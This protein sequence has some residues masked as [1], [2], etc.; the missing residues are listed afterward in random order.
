M[1]F[2]W[3]LPL[4]GICL[5]GLVEF[6][7]VESRRL[8]P[9]RTTSL[10]S[11]SFPG[12]RLS[13]SAL[14]LSWPFSVVELLFPWYSSFPGTRLSGSVSFFLDQSHVSVP[15]I[16]SSSSIIII[17]SS[18]SGQLSSLFPRIASPWSALLTLSPDR[19]SLVFA[20]LLGRSSVHLVLA[21]PLLFLVFASL[22][23]TRLSLVDFSFLR[24]R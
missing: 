19:L 4:L 13:G 6:K 1:L 22:L 9:R 7:R 23:G 11:V 17:L 14:P 15:K 3:Y 2:T 10:E 18:L 21:S 12:I 8:E 24:T 20:S 16:S 5:S